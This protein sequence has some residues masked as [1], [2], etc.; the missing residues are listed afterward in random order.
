[1]KKIIGLL[2]VLC[3]SFLIASFV[4]VNTIHEIGVVNNGSSN[5]VLSLK[6]DFAQ[7]MNL[8]K[9]NDRSVY[10]DLKN[11]RLDKDLISSYLADVSVVTQQIGSKVRI[12]LKGKNIDNIEVA[13]VGNNGFMPIDYN[14]IAIIC[15][16]LSLISFV[17]TKISSATM[18]L[19]EKRVTL[20]TPVQSAMNLNRQFYEFGTRKSPE[21]VLSSAITNPIQTEVYDFQYAKNR[22]NIK[23]AI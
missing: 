7:K 19:K 1:M 14:Q 22:K 3:I 20:I 6:S 21:L 18:K 16:L 13:F 9:E 10:Y 12:Y 5:L 4:N 23:I 15:G 17:A 2:S 8:V 11:A